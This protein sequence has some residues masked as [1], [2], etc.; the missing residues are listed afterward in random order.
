MS[1]LSWYNFWQHGPMCCLLFAILEN[2]FFC[3]WS[4]LN[5]RC[6]LVL[7]VKF[8]RS[9]SAEMFGLETALLQHSCGSV[10]NRY[11][12]HYTR[13][14]WKLPQIIQQIYIYFEFKLT[15]KHLGLAVD[16]L[17]SLCHGFVEFFCGSLHEDHFL[18]AWELK[19][20]P[21][22]F[23][24]RGYWQQKDHHMMSICKIKVDTGTRFVR[25]CECPKKYLQLYKYCWNYWWASIH[26]LIGHLIIPFFPTRTS[27]GAQ[28]SDFTKKCR[29]VDILPRRF[30]PLMVYDH[31]RTTYVFKYVLQKHQQT[32][33]FFF[34]CSI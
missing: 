32:N 24:T 2:L 16:P 28:S 34:C 18:V 7:V 17:Q 12:K 25:S 9:P 21:P 11:P 10:E 8:F 15:Q 31:L 3:W 33:P 5:A 30:L 23:F 29:T 26:R 1:R 13:A 4:L 14:T 22:W 19:L 20:P 27:P 6:A